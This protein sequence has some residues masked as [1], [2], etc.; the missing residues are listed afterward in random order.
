MNASLDKRPLQ[1]LVTANTE[2]ASQNPTSATQK[3]MSALPPKA[4]MCGARTHVRF[5]PIA[6]IERWRINVTNGDKRT[7]R[8]ASNCDVCFAPIT[9][10]SYF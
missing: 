8:E 10:R 9:G 1:Y 5:G 4:D 2:T 6:D 7:L 3:V